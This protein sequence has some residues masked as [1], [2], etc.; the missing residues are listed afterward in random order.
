MSGLRTK[1]V[2]ADCNEPFSSNHVMNVHTLCVAARDMTHGEIPFRYG[3]TGFSNHII[4][5]KIKNEKPLI[6]TKCNIIVQNTILEIVE[7]F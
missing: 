2:K 3:A 4:T 7:N 5:H 6:C 1:C